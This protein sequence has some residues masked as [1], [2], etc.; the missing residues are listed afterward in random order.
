[1]SRHKFESQKN[2]PDY[3]ED[4]TSRDMKH[5]HEDEE[6]PEDEAQTI[7]DA[8]EGWQ[9]KNPS[10]MAGRISGT[11]EE[12]ER[13]QSS[14]MITSD[15]VRQC[16]KDSLDC[17]QSCTDTTIHCLN[18]R[19]KH[20]EPDHINL[21]MDCAKICNLNADFMIRNSIYYPQTCGI[22]ADICDECADDC[23]RFDE[24]FMKE[25][26]SACRR[27]AESCREMAR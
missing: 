14:E 6:T 15:E 25:C 5:I 18:L 3:I 9:Q 21:L 27:C 16:I 19:G 13:M 23:D 1:M 2:R 4:L 12:L 11:M 8:E 10:P 24:D 26:A 17:Y 7:E 22:C 20:A